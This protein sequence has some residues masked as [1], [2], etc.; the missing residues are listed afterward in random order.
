VAGGAM[1]PA[2]PPAE[3]SPAL[4]SRTVTVL[5][6]SPIAGTDGIPRFAVDGVSLGGD[7]DAR[8]T[9]VELDPDVWVDMGRPGTLTVTIEPGDLLNG[10]SI[11]R[12]L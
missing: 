8:L 1:L 7:E 4:L 3:G 10:E 12:T 11:I 5:P 2:M 9:A 6:L